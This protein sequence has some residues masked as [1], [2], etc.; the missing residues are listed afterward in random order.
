MSGLRGEA[1]TSRLATTLRALT[2]ASAEA[3]AVARCSVLRITD[4]RLLPVASQFAGGTVSGE[5]W[6]TFK[7]LE[8]K[9]TPEPPGVLADLLRTRRGVLVL[10]VPNH[11]GVPT[12]WKQ[13]G[14]ATALLVPLVCRDAVVGLLL[15]D[16]TAPGMTRA[17]RRCALQ[18]A[19]AHALA[20]VGGTLDLDDVVRRAVHA[21]VDAERVRVDAIL[22]DTL[23]NTV[24]SM[25]MKIELAL[26]G[27]GNPS[28]LRTA[29]RALKQDAAVM[30]SQMR[31]VV[32]P[33]DALDPLLE[34]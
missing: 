13:F 10:D 16:T 1:L 23:R 6:E 20:I 2:R 34:A 24:F 8:T 17:Q 22:H 4:G 28:S 26:T 3:C 27:N 18:L 33:T 19:R 25:A 31:D 9:L 7:A 15:F 11:P 29:L 14:A 12:E 30:M 5:L 32:P 21:A